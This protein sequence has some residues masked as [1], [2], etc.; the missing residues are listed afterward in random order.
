MANTLCNVP[1]GPGKDIKR[2][3][4]K[5]HFLSLNVVRV[6]CACWIIGGLGT[7]RVILE[8][9]A[10]CDSAHSWCIYSAAR[11][12]DRDYIALNHTIP[13]LS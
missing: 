2:R 9:A 1:M 4:T 8:W 7:L 3:G 5:M 11:L 12:E 6:N 10:S 13:I